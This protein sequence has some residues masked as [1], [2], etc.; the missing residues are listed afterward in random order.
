MNKQNFTS[1]KQKL[2]KLIHDEVSKQ[3]E[4]NEVMKKVLLN[5]IIPDPGI[6]HTRLRAKKV[7]LQTKSVQKKNIKL[8]MKNLKGEMSVFGGEKKVGTKLRAKPPKSMDKLR[9]KK[10]NE[11]KDETVVYSDALQILN[12]MSEGKK[13]R[14]M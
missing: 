5:Q 7:V 8:K 9:G 10:D 3:T 11:K 2:G 1:L 12:D 13:K 14:I 4:G 6:N